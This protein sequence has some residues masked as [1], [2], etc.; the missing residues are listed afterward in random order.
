M[1][2]IVYRSKP[3]R[4]QIELIDQVSHSWGI[5]LGWLR[6]WAEDAAG[7]AGAAV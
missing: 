3:V 4:I 5:R 2:K 1:N 6:P 7:S